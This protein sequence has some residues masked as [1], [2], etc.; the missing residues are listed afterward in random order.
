VDIDA[1]PDLLLLI[2]MKLHIVQYRYGSLSSFNSPQSQFVTV[3]SK[4]RPAISV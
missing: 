1:T 3:N 2:Q 4:M